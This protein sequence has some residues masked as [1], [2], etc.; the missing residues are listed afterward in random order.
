METKTLSTD[1][2][3]T[4]YVDETP[5]GWVRDGSLL[6]LG[7]PGSRSGKWFAISRTGHIAE[8][9]HE[10]VE[11]A[12][13]AILSVVGARD[14]DRGAALHEVALIVEGQLT[15]IL[16]VSGMNPENARGL[17]HRQLAER[18]FEVTSVDGPGATHGRYAVNGVY[19]SNLI[20]GYADSLVKDQMDYV[21]ADLTAE[22]RGTR[23]IGHSTGMGR[24]RA[25]SLL[26]CLEVAGRALRTSDPRSGNYLWSLPPDEADDPDPLFEM[27]TD[28]RERTADALLRSVESMRSELNRIER[29]AR[30]ARDGKPIRRD[31]LEVNHQVASE[32]ASNGVR[33]A[34]LWE[35]AGLVA[36]FGKAGR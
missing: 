36:R 33:L 31:D 12:V 10:T 35:T 3:Y 18:G 19:C 30:E 6:E 23:A 16:C 29:T 5:V 4:V 21:E 14:F 20:A 28:A 13:N 15:A 9:N 2:G 32:L 26:S 11:D 22:P 27:T 34:T 8:P 1:L 7:E 24:E 25:L 17:A